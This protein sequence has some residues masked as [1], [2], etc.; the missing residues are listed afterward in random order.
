MQQQGFDYTYDKR[1]YDRLVEGHAGPVRDHF[2]AG[3]DYQNKLARFLEN[4]D[5]P[6]AAVTFPREVHEAAA[7]IT[8]LSPGLR[9]FHQGQFEGRR[10]RISPHLV[11]APQEAVD[12]TLN[13]FY[14]R[15]LALLRRPVV[16]EGQWQLVEASP[17]W[18]GNWTAEC[19]VAF[20]WHGS[21]GER[22][23]VAV[24]YAPNQSQG[25]L[26]LPFTDLPGCQWRLQDVIGAASYDRGGDDLQ[27]RG[28][29][30]DL[31][32]WQYHV[33]ELRP[34][35]LRDVA[36]E[37]STAV[38]SHHADSSPSPWA[39][40]AELAALVP[41]VI[42]LSGCVDL[43]VHDARSL[44]LPAFTRAEVVG[45]VA[46]LGTTF[47]SFPDLIAM[48][49][50]RSSAGM[51]SRMAAIMCV[52]QVLWIW[53]GLLIGS[54]PVIVW[55]I[56]AVVMNALNVGAHAYFARKERRQASGASAA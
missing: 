33:F 51:N 16:R 35:H 47:A 15:L 11:R 41:S 52:F 20:A 21:N 23:V 13:Q 28:L 7:L 32:P 37:E 46:G 18:K 45:F 6:R 24:N 34:L 44:L 39:R 49:K 27:A 5:E 25:Y 31:P 48:L 3:L 42:A 43:A 22:L 1:L 12:E 30:L 8:Y 19:L 56:V 10:K 29:Y 53:Y 36:P 38:T 9:F 17:A 55:N 54:R 26:R 14:L 50:R 40:L 4:H 2:R